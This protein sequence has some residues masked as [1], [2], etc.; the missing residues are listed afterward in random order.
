MRVDLYDTAYENYGVDVYAQIR[1]ETYGEDLGQTSWVTTR[2]SNEIPR[3]LELAET[4]RIIEVG[5]GS[6]R[7]ALRVAAQT[8]S[9]ILGLDVNP[10][11]IQT[12]NALASTQGLES[13][14]KFQECDASKPLAF[15]DGAF[16]AVFSNDVLCHLP[17]R[18]AVLSELARVLRPGGKLLFSDALIV[19]GFIT[20]EELATR[21]SIGFYVFS[22]PGANEHLIE[23]AGFEL[24]QTMDTT[25]SVALLA[26]RWCDARDRR[27][28]ELSAREGQANYEGLQRFL[29]FTHILASERRLLRMVYLARKRE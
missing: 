25:E 10:Y 19:G 5:C 24:L 11:G 8:G 20:N 15:D 23:T 29:S 18:P 16:D 21:S 2:E 9:R 12:A 28:D 22:S 1:T 7:Y 4:S 13:L 27:S 6:G 17:G 26:R 14:V 3:L